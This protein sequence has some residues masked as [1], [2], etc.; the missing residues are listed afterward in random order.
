MATLQRIKSAEAHVFA[1]LAPAKHPDAAELL[2]LKL[3][4]FDVDPNDH[5]A[6]I[7]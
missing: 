2:E 3:P 7:D 1:S 5:F 6:F 4:R